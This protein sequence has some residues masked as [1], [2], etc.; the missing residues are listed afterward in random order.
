[1]VKTKEPK[2][3]GL[4]PKDIE[5]IRK[6]I[7]QVW[8]WSYP[9]KLVIQRCTGLDGFMK[10]EMCIKRVPKIFVD[11]IQAVGKVDSGF[12]RR[13][14]C[15]STKLQ[16]LCK[17]CHDAKTREERKAD[18]VALELKKPIEDFS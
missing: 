18:K 13:L 17:K 3:D 11:H 16:G 12:I 1:M 5:N 9:K 7:R 10:C 2:L 15:P 14:F 4:S 8:H 6:A